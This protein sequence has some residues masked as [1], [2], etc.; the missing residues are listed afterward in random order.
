ML[1]AGVLWPQADYSAAATGGA[2]RTD[3]H[4]TGFAR[5]AAPDRAAGP[6]EV[7]RAAEAGRDRRGGHGRT[8]RGLGARPGGARPDRAGGPGAR[9]RPRAHAPRALHRRALR[10]GGRDADPPDP[11]PHPRL[12][13]AV[14]AQARAVHDEQP[15]G[16]RPP[17]RPSVAAR[18]GAGHAGVS[19]VHARRRGVRAPGRCALGRGDRRIRGPGRAR[20]GC[21]LGRDREGVGPLLHPASSS[22]TAAG[23]RAPSRRSAC[24]S[25]RRP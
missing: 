16:V 11:R 25:S 18:G 24:S 20:G 6:A 4:P 22:S 14:R 15:A 17:G 8:R 10:R 2:G 5:G 19:P 23:P 21:R 12:L 1:A 3:G 9:G 7:G 13:R